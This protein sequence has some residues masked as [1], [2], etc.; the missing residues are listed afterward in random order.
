MVVSVP[1]N[2]LLKDE[3]TYKQW[4]L[5]IHSLLDAHGLTQFIEGEI[6]PPPETIQNPVNL[7]ETIPNPA[8]TTWYKQY[9]FIFSALIGTLTPI[10]TPHVSK[11]KTSRDI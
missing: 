2:I 10:V 3:F 8:Y 1:S 7:E 11:A 4:C 5:S 9:K 6:S